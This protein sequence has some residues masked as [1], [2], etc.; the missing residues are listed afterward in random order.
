MRTLHLLVAVATLLLWASPTQASITCGAATIADNAAAGRT[1]CTKNFYFSGTCD[2]AEKNL[3]LNDGT[4]T[5]ALVPPW[6]PVSISI[7][8]VWIVPRPPAP[9]IFYAFAGNSWNADIMGW[10]TSDG[11][12][13][14]MPPGTQ[15]QFPPAGTAA[16]IDLHFWCPPGGNPYAGY[17]TVVYAPNPS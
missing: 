2:G 10:I 17:Y 12:E 14:H 6:E 4:T 15:M 13:R 8:D 1:I 3:P 5:G 11:V 16:H 9:P 7:L